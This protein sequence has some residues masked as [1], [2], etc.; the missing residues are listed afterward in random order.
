MT[1]FGKKRY[2]ICCGEIILCKNKTHNKRGKNM[3]KNILVVMCCVLV[4]T[5]VLP[6]GILAREAT[7]TTLYVNGDTTD[8][9]SDSVRKL[10]GKTFTS[11]DAYSDMSDWDILG[12]YTHS[13][14]G[15]SL[16]SATTNALYNAQQFSGKYGAKFAFTNKTETLAVAYFNYQDANN[17]YSIEVDGYD[18]STNIKKVVNSSATVLASG[19]VAD[20][21]VPDSGALDVTFE[22]SVDNGDKITAWY[23]VDGNK[24]TLCKNLEVSGDKLTSGK[25]G[26]GFKYN[27][28]EVV[29]KTVNVYRMPVEDISNVANT[30]KGKIVTYKDI[31]DALVAVAFYKNGNLVDVF[32][33]DISLLEGTNDFSID[34]LSEE[35]LAG[36]KV[37][38]FLFD[39]LSN[40]KPLVVIADSSN[41][42]NEGFSDALEPYYS[43]ASAA[44]K[45]VDD[46]YALV[47]D[48]EIDANSNEEEIADRKAVI[49]MYKKAGFD[50]T[51]DLN[52]NISSMVLRAHAPQTYS[53]LTPKPLTGN[54]EQPYS[55]DA[56]WNNPIPKA[57]PRTE[58]TSW[59]TETKDTD[60]S[61]TDVK[62]AV[63]FQFT[64][65][66]PKGATNGNGLGIPIIIADENDGFETFANKYST[67]YIVTTTGTKIRVPENYGDMLNDISTGDRHGVFIDDTT[68]MGV[69]TWSTVASN[70]M[71][72]YEL[73][74]G[75]LKDFDA[76]AGSHT[77]YIDLSG[78]GNEMRAGVNAAGIPMDA[79]TI[80]S[81]DLDDDGK[82]IN[83]ALGAA[84]GT[85]MR[86][87][88]YPAY[89]MDSGILSNTAAVGC[90]P[91]GG[92]I[93]LD[94][95]LDL[96]GMYASGKLSLPGYKILKAWRDYG[97]YNVDQSTS[98]MARGHL[99]IY[100]SAKF[101]DWADASNEK[102]NVPYSNNAQGYNAVQAEVAAVIAGNSFFGLTKPVS[103]YVT[104]PVVKT[105]SYDADAD[106]EI[107]SNDISF[108]EKYIGDILT[109][110]T[111]SCDINK[112][113]E[114][115]KADAKLV[116]NYL[117]GEYP[118]APKTYSITTRYSANVGWSG[119]VNVTGLSSVTN[120]DGKGTAQANIV[121]YTKQIP[122]NEYYS[123]A[124]VPSNGYVF[125]SWVNEELAGET[126]NVVVRKAT[127]DAYYSAKF[128]RAPA[129]TVVLEKNEDGEG[130]IGFTSTKNGGYSTREYGTLSD[131]K[132]ANYQCAF[133][134]TPAEG[135][136]FESWEVTADDV[137]KVY[138]SS[139][140]NTLINAD[141]NIK[142]NFIKVNA[143]DV[144]DTLDT[145]VWESVSNDGDAI[146]PDTG[147][148][149]KLAY[150]ASDGTLRF[151]SGVDNVE[152]YAIINN[153][154]ASLG[155]IT[156]LVTAKADNGVNSNR[157]RVV[158]GY[159]DVKNYWYVDFSPKTEEIRLRQAING[160]YKTHATYTPDETATLDFTANTEIH[161]TTTP[162]GKISAYVYQG[163]NEY[164][165][166]ENYD[167][168]EVV[169]GKMGL[170]SSHARHIIF[171]NFAVIAN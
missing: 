89:D 127:S 155:D 31:G 161:I 70:T 125:D 100:S 170:G 164:V 34:V 77:S 68:K 167:A 73:A 169:V 104:T 153:S 143:Y 4:L 149:K 51:A 29:I 35:N 22:V 163:E 126:S 94:P 137:T 54:Y 57:N 138:H 157:G 66:R 37:K 78:M 20:L 74:G 96:E 62:T 134:A 42:R 21:A 132:Y 3:K 17:Y 55:I 2:N 83:H 7:D 142:A 129:V 6:L 69:H 109:L 63:N 120:Y 84:L 75:L 80:K 119:N 168:G 156:L 159:K 16:T 140:L 121:S 88:V 97:M 71:R 139:V 79:I 5:L 10:Y 92:I 112:D 58:I 11:L 86:A 32:T 27:H 115:T 1:L 47:A 85:V 41:Y 108:I 50:I 19:I 15:M 43:M 105:T 87:R 144:F 101:D 135:Y 12:V 113:G 131:V 98:D 162:E 103:F 14:E 82:D 145:E 60:G 141:T 147:E 33:K 160:S 106:G 93:Q 133:K 24:V 49:D 65:V 154:I 95:S 123:V 81:A 158:F 59:T 61:V 8:I 26:L 122:E 13:D 118:H 128:K 102:Y 165:L 146:D 171:D 151:S 23:T 99:L 166:V 136:V 117:N 90:I 38:C 45:T 110:K 39:S 130:T 46:M 36:T 116:E 40:I 76:R 44:S 18:G 28:H 52:D 107:S 150:V 148:V 152:D 53:H 124:A 111:E 30:V 9:Y 67:N 56:P 64:A 91:Y 114:I 25:V 72:G 48:S